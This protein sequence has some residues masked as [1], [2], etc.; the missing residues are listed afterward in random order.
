M[1]SILTGMFAWH[2]IYLLFVLVCTVL[3]VMRLRKLQLP[4]LL[5]A[6]PLLFFLADL[7]TA[8]GIGNQLTGFLISGGAVSSNPFGITPRYLLLALLCML[9]L[10]LVPDRDHAG[11]SK[12]DRWGVSGFM[13]FG[14]LVLLA[15]GAALEALRTISMALPGL[16][17]YQAT[18][19]FQRYYFLYGNLVIILI[20]AVLTA[21]QQMR[22]PS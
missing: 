10:A 19:G 1:G 12:L 20:F 4:T 9:F 22:R 2:A 8:A 17:P 21:R 6:I 5:V 7:Q 14:M 11:Q 18:A 16:A 3:I 13:M 15:I